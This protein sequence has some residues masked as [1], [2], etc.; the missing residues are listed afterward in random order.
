MNKVNS[1]ETIRSID[2]LPSRLTSWVYWR[3]K[4]TST[5]GEAF[6]LLTEHFAIDSGA[7]SELTGQ[8][9]LDSGNGTCP[10]CSN[11]YLVKD[12]EWGLLYCLHYILDWQREISSRQREFRS[13]VNPATL[14]D[15]TY[16]KGLGQATIRD[17]KA[18]VNATEKFIKQPDK[19]LLLL[20]HY[21]LGK[22]HMLRTINTAFRPIALYIAA[23][24]IEGF[25]HS[26]R[27]KDTLNEF[28]E[29]LT[30]APV[31]V[32][33]DL[34]EEYGGRLVKSVVDRV[35]NARYERFPEYPVVVASNFSPQMLQD[36]L[37]R[38][39]DRLFD[40]ERCVQLSIDSKTSYR[41]L[42]PELRK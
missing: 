20:G 35:I 42:Y 28:I 13:P 5:K 29:R 6:D 14:D 19:W 21:G 2:L 25:T 18:M 41:K 10:F 16:P 4:S 7:A 17:L 40:K 36:Y 32:I 38:T 24:D 39:A 30:Y 37:P 3:N 26:T 12:D 33:D 31:L 11:T 22:T 8:M 23:R 9:I 27:K 1:Q 34:G 15:I